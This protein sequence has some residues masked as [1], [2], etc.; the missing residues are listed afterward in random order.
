MAICLD[1]QAVYCRRQF[2]VIS[3]R[4]QVAAAALLLFA[5]GFKVWVKVCMTDVGYRVAEERQRL[6]ELDRE[7]R[8]LKLQ[9]A[10]LLR[11]DNLRL[12]ATNRL[13]LVELTSDKIWKT[14]R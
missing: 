11:H 3:F 7:K 12:A 5:L 4:V 10:V 8:E 9:L 13:G 14:H 1:H 2:P 6:V